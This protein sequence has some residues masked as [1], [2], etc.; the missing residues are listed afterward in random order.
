MKTRPLILLAGAVTLAAASALVARALMRPA[1]PVTIVKEVPAASAPAPT[2]RVLT[3]DRAVEI[4]E[5]I[6]SDNVG[7]KVLPADSVHGDQLVGTTD[8]DRHRLERDV[9]GAVARQA[10]PA[11]TAL[12]RPLLVKAGEPGF[13]STVLPPGKRAVSIPTSVVASNAGLVSAGDRVDVIL[14]LNRADLLPPSTDPNGSFNLLAA[15][16]I[17][18][19]VRVLALDSTTEGIAPDM[20][21]EAPS[22]EDAAKR[23]TPTTQPV[24]KHVSATLEVSPEDAERLALAREAGTLQLALRGARETGAATASASSPTRLHDVSSVLKAAPA[25]PVASYRGATVSYEQPAQRP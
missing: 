13:L 25:A 2:L 19:N 17:V 1:P 20:G 14:N 11:G 24:K 21:A 8:A 5:F 4:G 6:T 16:T 12:R 15:Q 9:F 18:H 3:I 22:P 23:K 7:W 10:M